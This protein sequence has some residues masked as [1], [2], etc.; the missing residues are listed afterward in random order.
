MPLIASFTHVSNYPWIR[1]CTAS[2]ICCSSHREWRSVPPSSSTILLGS[3]Y[4]LG[5]PKGRPSPCWKRPP[6]VALPKN[7]GS[8]HYRKCAPLLDE[9]GLLLPLFPKSR[10]CS[11]QEMCP[12]PCLKWPPPVTHTQ[13]QGCSHYRK[14]AP[15]LA[16]YASIAMPFLFS[17]GHVFD[18]TESNISDPLARSM[19]NQLV[20]I[21]MGDKMAYCTLLSF[22]VALSMHGVGSVLGASRMDHFF[23]VLPRQ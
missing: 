18:T 23:V 15:P 6:P 21:P 22:Q 19:E 1:F 3:S 11:V 2:T 12:S 10:E 14:C 8:P 17:I 4:F 16:W 7:Q 13:N 5:I 20:S 9:S